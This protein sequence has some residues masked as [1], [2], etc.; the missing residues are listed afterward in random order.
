ML[1]LGGRAWNDGRRERL[2][3]PLFSL[4]PPIIP[5]MLQLFPLPRPRAN[6]PLQ[7]KQHERGFCR[8]EREL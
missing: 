1:S 5:Y 7:P 8:R 4:S 3:A 6:N 2:G